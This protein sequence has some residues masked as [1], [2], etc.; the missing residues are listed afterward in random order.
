MESES[1]I[2][3]KSWKTLAAWKWNFQKDNICTICTTEYELA[4]PGYKF[5]GDDSPIVIGRCGHAFHIQCIEKWLSQYHDSCPAC[6]Q[7]FVFQ[8]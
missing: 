5:P 4:A 8:K 3:I 6:R 2:K 1:R 7:E